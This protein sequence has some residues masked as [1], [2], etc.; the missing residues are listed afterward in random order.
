MP[1]LR[2]RN[3]KGTGPKIEENVKITKSREGF[4][5]R[6]KIDLEKAKQRK[7]P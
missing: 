6:P 1:N 2:F 3:V 7:F 4:L 5:R